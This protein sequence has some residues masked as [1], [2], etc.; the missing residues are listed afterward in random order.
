LNLAAFR[1]EKENARTQGV[2]D[3]DPV[4][5]EGEQLVQGF[6]IGV[7]GNITNDWA[8]FGGYTFLDSET[9][10]SANPA[11]I[12]KSLPN[13]PEHSFSLWTTYQLPWNLQ[14]GVGAQFVDDR[15]NNAINQREA[16]S[17]WNVDAMLTY[18][19][20]EHFDV[21][22]NVYNI[23]DEEY[24]DRVGGGHFIPGAGRAA[25]VT[26]SIKF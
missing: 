11:E 5:L 2:D 12:G 19:V 8:L 14:A 24:I 21:R 10:Q 15:F 9:K 17:Y 7:A 23:F 4:V 18:R 25:T 13:T 20:N 22:M 26:L 3:L 16:E 6:E 1:T